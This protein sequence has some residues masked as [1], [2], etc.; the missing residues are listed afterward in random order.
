MHLQYP[1]LHSVLVVRIKQELLDEQASPNAGSTFDFL[2][3]EFFSH[4]NS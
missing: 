1:S 4:V 2:P 3:V